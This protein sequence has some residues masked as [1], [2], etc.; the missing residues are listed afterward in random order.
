[1]SDN[2]GFVYWLDKFFKGVLIL[3]GFLFSILA[4]SI[5]GVVGAY[6][7]DLPAI[8][9]LKIFE[10]DKV[11][12]LYADNGEVFA[13]YFVQ[14][15]I[16][17]TLDQIPKDL[18][19][20]I[21]AIEDNNF[22]GHFGVDWRGIVRAAIVNFVSGKI[23]EGGSTITQQLA[24]VLFLTPEKTLERKIKEALV[25]LQLEKKYT[26]NEI[27]E[28]YLNQIYF[29][30]GAY[31]VEAAALT[32]FGKHVKDLNTAECAL[33][34]GLPR[35]PTFYSP[36]NNYEVAKKRRNLVLARM[37]ELGF[38]SYKKAEE[39]SKEPLKLSTERNWESKAPYFSEYIR[40]YIEDTYGA[41]LLYKK[42]IKV[43]T[44]LNLKMQKAAEKALEKGLM[45][46]SRTKEFK[47]VPESQRDLMLEIYS[48]TGNLEK[49]KLYYG[50]VTEIGMNYFTV[51][52]G[53]FYGRVNKENFQWTGKSLPRQIVKK[54]D[55]VGVSLAEIK[56]D[57]EVL[58]NLEN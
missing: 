3:I 13:E 41:E 10:P 17:I 52:V 25:A 45:E 30:S 16:L 46:I 7:R 31:G 18:I 38:I 35:L 34:A 37:A 11:T 9:K 21:L 6:L 47:T 50:E 19:K 14:R 58:F 15:R 28:L 40:K 44:P 2:R 8:E 33:I 56:K 32:Y 22:Y 42:G 29:G 5:G 53:K 24:K 43:Y 55:V 49:E 23:R 4:G 54:G 27:L 20:A 36:F 39:L 26:K 57:G 1:M 51:K 48:K 12:R